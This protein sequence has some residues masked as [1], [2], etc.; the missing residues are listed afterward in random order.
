[1]SWL[2]VTIGIGGDSLRTFRGGTGIQMGAK[3]YKKS[4]TDL[5]YSQM[6]QKPAVDAVNASRHRIQTIEVLNA[7]FLSLNHQFYAPFRLLGSHNGKCS[8]KSPKIG[9]K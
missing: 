3:L 7:L 2:N 9:Q 6:M 1:M 8:L 4:K 5:R